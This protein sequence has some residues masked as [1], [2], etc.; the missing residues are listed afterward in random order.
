MT[1]TTPLTLN[2]AIR[3]TLENNNNIEVARSDVRINET[4]LQSLEGVFDPTFSISPT[5][6][7]NAGLQSS[8]PSTNFGLNLGYSQFLRT[9]ATIEP[10]FNNTRNGASTFNNNGNFGGNFGGTGTNFG[11]QIVNPNGS[12]FSS[13]LGFTFRQPLLRNRSIDNTR[14]QITI[15][16]RR[17]QQSDADF[18]RITI[19][20]IA[21]VQTAYWDLVFAL[22]DQQNRQLNLN[23]T[24]ENMRRVEAQIEAGSAAPL[25]R[26]EVA[27]ELANREGDLLLA[28]QN[29]TAAENILKNLLLRDPNAPE[30]SSPLVPTDEPNFDSTPIKLED[31]LADARANRPELQ[32][33]NIQREINDIDLKFFR[34][35]TKPQIDLVS[36]VA[37]N[38]GSTVINGTSA[39]T[40]QLFT[41]QQDLAFLDRINRI[42]PRVNALG[43]EQIPTIVNT[44][45]NVAATEGSGG[46][47]TTFRDLFRADALNFQ[48]GITIGFPLRNKTAKADLA[49]ANIQRTQLEAQFRAQEQTVVSQV[50]NAVQNVETARLRIA[51]ARTARVNAQMQLEGEQTLFS[52]GRSTV[53]L[54]FQRENA[55]A[56]ARNAEIRAQTDLNKALA[57]LQRATSTTLRAN[58]IIVESP[59]AP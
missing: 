44:P 53:F 30:W 29:V 45:I 37:L 39:T 41:T 7:R 48:V 55:L 54:L 1:R 59:V 13:Q 14:R 33:L 5:Y 28:A 22:R 12:F 15:Q 11:A 16:R 51:T 35:Q 49:G 10:F 31:A 19:D 27:T 2:D 40:S 8:N 36:T 4:T 24:R 3:R 6:T 34:N 46:F 38:S 25:A 43:G 58:N 17:L 9:G 21:Q 42:I 18:R 20:T 52:V 23:L 26:A 47:G 57:E 50:R 32:R 56:N